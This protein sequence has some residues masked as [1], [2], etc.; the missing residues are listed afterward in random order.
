MKGN[1]PSS[2]LFTKLAFRKVDGS[3]VTSISEDVSLENHGY[4]FYI[5][6]N[7]SNGSGP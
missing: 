1:Y 6:E 4:E 5:W 7:K 2:Q 3:F